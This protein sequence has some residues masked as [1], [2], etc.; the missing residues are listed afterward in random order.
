MV[1]IGFALLVCLLFC[2]QSH[3][4]LRGIS[5]VRELGGGC[6][7]APVSDYDV[8]E[9]YPRGAGNYVGD[10]NGKL[11]DYEYYYD[12]AI[13]NM[14]NKCPLFIYTDGTGNTNNMT[15]RD[16]VLVTEMA[17]RGYFAVAVDFYDNLLFIYGWV[18]Q[19]AAFIY[20]DT[21]GSRSVIGQ[22]CYSPDLP[23]DCGLGV[24]AAGWSQGANIASLARNYCKWVTAALLF[25]NGYSAS[26]IINVNVK[27]TNEH[28][29]LPE[30][31]RRSIVGE[32]DAIFGGSLAGV[33]AQQI[34]TSGYDCSDHEDRYDCFNDDNTHAGYYIVP[35][36]PHNVM[37]CTAESFEKFK[38]PATKWGL[39]Q[40]FDWLSERG[41]DTEVC[42]SILPHIYL[43]LDCTFSPYLSF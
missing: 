3:A 38:D 6:D 33:E 27:T 9:D 40:N 25:G 43:A 4:A 11:Y 32:K 31:R 36:A 35:G 18:N 39:K 8:P 37:G 42:L 17:L 13:C 20:D 21:P 12:D 24:A 34:A 5:D 28:I 22:L 15:E 16:P 41:R 26:Y 2:K 23:I 14:S 19:K 10:Y 1:V 30:N 7:Y 29:L